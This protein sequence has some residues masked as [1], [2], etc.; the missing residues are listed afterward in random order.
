MNVVILNQILGTFMSLLIFAGFTFM[1]VV[2][3]NVI[4]IIISIMLGILTL[5]LT[6]NS[7]KVIK[8]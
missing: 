7:V 2:S 1:A 3:K 4:T 5:L 6:L 8:K